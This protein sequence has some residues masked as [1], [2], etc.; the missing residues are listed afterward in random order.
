MANANNSDNTGLMA[1]DGT[2]TFN[3]RTITAGTGISVANGDGVSGDPT[4]SGAATV[5]NQFVTDAGSAS[6]ALNNVNFLGG[7]GIAT[8]GSGST[9]TIAVDESVVTTSFAADSG[10]AT[11][12]AGVITFAG[13]TNVTT[14]ASG[15]TVT[16]DATGGGSGGAWTLLDT[17]T[18]SG[19]SNIDFTSVMT[20]AYH[21][22]VI[23]ISDMGTSSTNNL[24]LR[25]STDNGATFDSGASDYAWS[26]IEQD[27]QTNAPSQFGDN[28][29]TAIEL[30]NLISTSSQSLVQGEI[31]IYNP[32]AVQKTYISHNLVF[33]DGF[34]YENSIGFGVRNSVADVDA[35]RLR[36][37][38][39]DTG[40]FNLYGVTA[41]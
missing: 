40:T 5:A 22:F 31:K 38:S 23:I 21:Y 36:M 26:R 4:V 13:G 14:S 39:I 15:S 12:A 33:F 41:T 37:S 25:T 28:A 7:T 17:Q 9:V 30:T 10:T 24:R 35:I 18:A 19:A 32:F 8:S 1:F 3:G 6:P 20:S 11:P 16:F 27:L 29:D 34:S 2:D